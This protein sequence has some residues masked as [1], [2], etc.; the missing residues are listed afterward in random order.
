M[1][2]AAVGLSWVYA[3]QATS[4]TEALLE[5]IEAGEAFAIPP[6]WFTEIANSLLVLQR[7]GKITAPPRKNS[8]QRLSLLDMQVDPSDPSI[9]F[10]HIS[11]LAETYGLTVYDATYLELATRRGLPLA[12]RDDALAKAARRAGVPLL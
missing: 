12:T 1:I 5:R 6:L 11:D 3:S 8:L 10:Y 7:R 9:A 4:A 2:D